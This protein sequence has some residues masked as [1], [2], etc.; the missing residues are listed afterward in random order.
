MGENDEAAWPAPIDDGACEH[1]VGALLPPIELRSGRGA[2]LNLGE[3]ENL[4][5]FYL[6]PMSGADD[7]G[8]PQEW[9]SIPGARGCSPQAC[10][11][12][13]LHGDLLHHHATVF[14]VATQFPDYLAGEIARLELPYDLLSDEHFELQRALNIPLLPVEAGGRPVFRRLTLVCQQ[15]RVIK[16]FYPVFP[17]S[18]NAGE[19]LGWIK[20]QPAGGQL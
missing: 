12:R 10:G 8:L 18:A 1:L 7:S 19:V 20:T 11:F 15:A 4:T 14:G 13:D 3:L 9:D 6:Y 2:I 17:P 5:V 16:V